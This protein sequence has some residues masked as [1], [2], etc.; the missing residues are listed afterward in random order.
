MCWA[1]THAKASAAS[2]A[3]FISA[4]SECSGA[5][6]CRPAKAEL[7]SF[8]V[9]VPAIYVAGYELSSAGGGLLDAEHNAATPGQHRRAEC[10]SLRSALARRQRSPIPL[11]PLTCGTS[12]VLAPPYLWHFPACDSFLLE[13]AK[14]FSSRL[15]NSGCHGGYYF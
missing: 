6:I 10:A 11:H 8:V 15:N 3:S 1:R 9:R 4:S 5:G 7:G 2:A 13:C 12:L 14:E